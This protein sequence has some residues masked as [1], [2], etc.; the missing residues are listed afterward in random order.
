MIISAIYNEI[1][2]FRKSVF[3]C[4]EILRLFSHMTTKFQETYKPC[5]HGHMKPIHISLIVLEPA[6]TENEDSEYWLTR[7][8]FFQPLYLPSEFQRR[9]CSCHGEIRI[10]VKDIKTL[11]H[12][13]ESLYVWDHCRVGCY[14]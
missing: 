1:N 13:I 11:S 10:N 3:W 5:D 14:I 7:E 8:Q 4:H 6:I 2:G 12:F 9:R